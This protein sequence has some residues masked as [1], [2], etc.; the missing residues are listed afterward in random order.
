MRVNGI[1]GINSNLDMGPDGSIERIINMADP[2]LPQ[3]AA[4]KFYVDS[5]SPGSAVHVY[6]HY[7]NCK[8]GASSIGERGKMAEE[9]GKEAALELKSAIDFDGCLDKHMAD[10]ILPYMALAVNR[11][12]ERSTVKVEEITSHCKTN[13][14]V[15]E[16]FLPVK[17]DIDGQIIT[18]S[19]V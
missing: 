4:T 15:I 5:L 10:Q 14:W 13:I 9:V 19:K 7:D 12:G 6:A 8:L 1:V 16:K 3:D 11:T 18:V 17:F 2:I